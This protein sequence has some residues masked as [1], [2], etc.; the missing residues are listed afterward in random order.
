[1]ALTRRI[2]GSLRRLVPD[3]ERIMSPARMPPSTASA[4]GWGKRP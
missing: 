4:I 2:G 1:V 3:R